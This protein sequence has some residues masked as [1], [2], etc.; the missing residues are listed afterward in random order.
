MYV[1]VRHTV[2]KHLPGQMLDGFYCTRGKSCDR[3]AA[4][5]HQCEGGPQSIK[6][7]VLALDVCFSRETN[8]TEFNWN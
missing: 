8:I 1:Y 4:S 5:K 3:K 6:Q 2:L 7:I